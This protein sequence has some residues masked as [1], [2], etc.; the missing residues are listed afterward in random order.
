MADNGYHGELR[1][2]GGWMYL[3]LFGFG[4]VSPV[5]L[6][7]S[8]ARGLYSDVAVERLLGDRW[9]IYQVANWLMIALALTIIGTVV[10]RLFKFQNPQTVRLTIVSIPLIGFGMP[11]LDTLITSVIARIEPG[12]ILSEYTPDLIRSTVYSAIWCSYFSVSKRVKATYYAADR[13]EDVAVFE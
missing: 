13:P 4:F 7:I 6:V 10:W 2:V 5:M 11:L 9:T 12:L 1:G 3:F 8:M